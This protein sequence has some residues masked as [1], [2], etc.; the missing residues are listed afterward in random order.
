[1]RRSR[2][3]T[4]C[5]GFDRRGPRFFHLWQ[6]H[7]AR[8]HGGDIEIG[9]R[10]GHRWAVRGAVSC[11]FV[12]ADWSDIAAER[13]K[14]PHAG[15]ASLRDGAGLFLAALR[16]GFFGKIRRRDWGMGA[17]LIWGFLPFIL[18]L[19]AAVGWVLS[20]AGAVI[21]AVLAALSWMFGAR[22]GAHYIRQ[23]AWAARRLALC[24]DPKIEARIAALAA[25]F[26]GD[27]DEEIIVGHSLGAVVALRLVSRLRD[28]GVTRPITLL[29]IGH[30]IPLVSQQREAQALRQALDVVAR[31]PATTWIDIS[32]GRDLLAFSGFDPSGGGAACY[33]ARLG[34]SFET[35]TLDRL[36][37]DGFAMHFQYFR[38]AER[39]GA[40]WDWFDILSGPAPV[41]ERFAQQARLAGTGERRFP[42]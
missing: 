20:T 28:Q 36:R 12:F 31:D 3:I 8:R 15:G 39:P 22:T 40:A 6:K 4:Y 32:A 29:T 21:F 9:P 7:E 19:A 2:R 34:D 13:L 30:S 17:M 5:H 37:W 18:I 23:I 42:F 25:D 33:S 27:A 14:I 11:A 16:Q 1:M 41:A 24:D 38:A 26:A 10:S 35:S